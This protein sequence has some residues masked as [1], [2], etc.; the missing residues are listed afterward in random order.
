MQRRV[1]I[2]K[3][4]KDITTPP[5]GVLIVTIWDEF[6][7]KSDFPQICLSVLDVENRRKGPF[8]QCAKARNNRHSKKKG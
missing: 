7:G 6:R 1:E 2:E 3:R 4:S 8:L 5:K